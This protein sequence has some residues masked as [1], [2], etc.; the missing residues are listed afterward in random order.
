[1][2]YVIQVKQERTLLWDR[3]AR[4]VVIKRVVKYD[5]LK[6]NY[7]AWE[8]RDDTKPEEEIEFE[9]ELRKAEYKKT[10]EN[11][12]AKIAARGKASDGPSATD[13]DASPMMDPLIL[14]TAGEMMQWMSD[15]G[16]VD[17]GPMEGLGGQ[18]TYY[19]MARLKVKSMNSSPPLT[20]ILFFVSFLD[21]DT[22]WLTSKPFKVVDI[23]LDADPS[24]DP[25][26]IRL[27]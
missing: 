19:A 17:M 1:F 2:T 26:L 15:T 20:Y 22:G 21:F 7:L 25:D 9:E 16:A 27:R 5:T 4:Q 8:K 13:A 23:D 11:T 12:N 18:G 6:K 10:D 14:L 3:S 24:T